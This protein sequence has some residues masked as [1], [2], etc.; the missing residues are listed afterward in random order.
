MKK[1]T[2]KRILDIVIT[3]LTAIVTALTTTSCMG[4]LGLLK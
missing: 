2:W 3:I 4:E 1:E